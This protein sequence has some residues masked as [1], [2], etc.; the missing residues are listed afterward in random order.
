MLQLAA[1]K[2]FGPKTYFQPNTYKPFQSFFYNYEYHIIHIFLVTR[3]GILCSLEDAVFV[4]TT[5]SVADSNLAGSVGNSF[6]IKNFSL[7]NILS[8]KI[9][10]GFLG[11]EIS[12]KRSP[13]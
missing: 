13:C 8:P 1:K 12:F 4:E 7:A 6:R 9:F 11:I 5:T 2:N 3:A 10:L